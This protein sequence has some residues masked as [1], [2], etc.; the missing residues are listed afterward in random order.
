M[1]KIVQNLSLDLLYLNLDRIKKIFQFTSGIHECGFRAMFLWSGASFHLI[2]P[3]TI[4]YSP[5]PKTLR[6]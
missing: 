5:S 6:L 1:I 2:N 4:F 3:S